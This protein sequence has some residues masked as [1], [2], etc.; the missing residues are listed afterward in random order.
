MTDL[1]KYFYNG[2]FHACFQAAKQLE[3]DEQLAEIAKHFIKLFT[4]YEYDAVPNYTTTT[5]KQSI[6][7]PDETYAELD[8]VE[9]IRAIKEEAL[10]AEAIQAL[11]KEAKNGDAER[12]AQSFF[13]QGQLFLLAHHYDES[14]Y[15]FQQA[16][17]HNPNKA[18]FYGYAAQTM[19]RFSWS[20]FDIMIYLER[21]IELDPQNARWYWNKSLVLTQLYKDLQQEA[22]LENALLT[23]EQA[24]TTCRSRA[25][26]TKKC[27]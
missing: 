16:V 20:P 7:R 6:E 24:L 15:C 22:F 1:E 5:S 17:K 14:I 2:R 27:D 9:Q 25:N 11:E 4:Q 12:K 21:A 3:T 13:A 23:L 19:H 8:E 18:L 10:F 26:L